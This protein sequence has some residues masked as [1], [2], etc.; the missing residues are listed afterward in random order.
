MQNNIVLVLVLV[1]SFTVSY[2]TLEILRQIM[3]RAF[4][5]FGLI[6]FVSMGTIFYLL[7]STMTYPLINIWV[8]LLSCFFLF[9]TLTYGVICY[10]EF[11]E[12]VERLLTKRAA[13]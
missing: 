10:F 13:D 11:S 6:G 1:G 5:L 12:I 3:L 2:I 7:L 9:A 4:W 8:A